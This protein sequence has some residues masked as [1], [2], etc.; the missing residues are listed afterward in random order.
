MNCEAYY[1]FE[2][3]SSDHRIISAKIHQSLCRNKRQTVK[4]SQYDGSS[5]TNSDIRN[6]YMVTVRN[7]FDTLQETSEKHTPN[8]EYENFVTTHMEAAAECIP[9]KPRAKCRVLWEAI[10]IRK[11]QDNMKNEP[12]NY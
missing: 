12:P 11:K 5:P 10:A 1:S 8:D 3:V 2:G 9:A 7:K 4:A 6:H